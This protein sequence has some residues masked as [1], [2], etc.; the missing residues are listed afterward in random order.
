MPRSRKNPVS[1][2]VT[3]RQRLEA[4]ISHGRA[5][6]R[7]LTHAR[8]LL[9][10]DESENTPDEAWSDTG[11]ADALESRRSTVFRVRTRFAR[12]GSGGCF[13]PSPTEKH[14]AQKARWLRRGASDRSGLLRTST[15]QKA[16]EREAFGGSVRG[17]GGYRGA[18]IPGIGAA[19]S[20]KSKLKPWLSGQWSIPPQQDADFVWRMEDVLEVYTR[21]YDERF[22]QVC[23]D[24]KSKQ[25]VSDVREPLAAA[26]GRPARHD[27]EYER[28]GTANLFIISEPL[29]GWRHIKV[30]E[31]RTKLDWAQCI[32]ELV[33][34]HYPH[35]EK[36][37]LVMDN[38]NTH[39]PAALYEAF[40]PA[41]ARR[42]ASRLQIHYT[43]KHGSWLNMAEIELSVLARQCLDQRIPDCQALAEEVGAWESERNASESSIEWRF[44]TDEARI[45]LKHLYPEIVA[46][47]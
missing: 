46:S 38:L 9:K 8:I 34:I 45:K 43:P 29:A 23:L 42:L 47:T 1:L 33:D 15:G 18:C 19:H 32:Q 24:E 17:V 2:S 36:I 3:D 28:N 6:A 31:R 22:P 41:Q 30:T 14:Q 13:S 35:A 25:L 10:A 16:L 21:S 37:V 12:E 20:Q 5:P 26:A 40:T 27:Y 39:T 44:T 4:M 7:Q 11:I